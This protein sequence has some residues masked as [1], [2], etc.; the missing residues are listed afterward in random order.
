[1]PKVSTYPSV[2]LPLDGTETLYGV[3][4][5]NSR[6]LTTGDIS[7]LARSI[8]D[9]RLQTAVAAAG[10]TSIDFTGIPAWV[11]RVNLIFA[12]I[13]TNGTS[14]RIVQ[15]GDGAFATTLYVGGHGAIASGSA[16]AATL[17]NGFALG[18]Q[19]VAADTFHGTMTISRQSGNTWVAT[20]LGASAA[21]NIVAIAGY[22]R[23]LTGALDRVRLTTAGGVDTFDAG[24]VNVSWE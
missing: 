6:K 8:S 18:L 20:A 15:I 23:S 10:Q 13:S 4:G 14:V 16:G 12:G 19:N 5:G 11:N 3:Q 1:M 2:S 7:E 9:I 22:S 21:G 17:T 24:S